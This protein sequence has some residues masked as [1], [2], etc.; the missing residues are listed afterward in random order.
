MGANANDAR[1][2]E[3]HNVINNGDFDVF[4]I[5]ETNIHW[6]NNQQHVRD[7]TYG[8]FRKM[9]ITYQYYKDYPCTAK[10]QVGGV[11]QLAIGDTASRV[12]AHG[13]DETGQ[14]R[15]TWQLFTGRGRQIRIVTAYRP[16]RNTTNAGSVWNQQQYYADKHNIGGNPQERWLK[17]LGDCIEQ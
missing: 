1:N 3:L 2:R 13:G 5:T 14:G 7:C 11:L 6:Q 17:D 10:F 15:W 4:G 16:V 8:W 9:N 12:T